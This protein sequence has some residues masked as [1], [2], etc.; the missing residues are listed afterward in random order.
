MFSGCT[1]PPDI[2][3]TKLEGTNQ[4]ASPS[5]VKNTMVVLVPCWVVLVLQL[6]LMVWI[7]L[8]S[9]DVI[10]FDIRV[11]SDDHKK[12]FKVWCLMNSQSTFLFLTYF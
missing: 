9:L 2:K 3:E 11:L 5:A 12:Y 1:L 10:C 4:E 7:F 8:R 6:L